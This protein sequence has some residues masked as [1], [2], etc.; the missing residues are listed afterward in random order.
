MNLPNYISVFRILLVP[1]FFMFLIDFDAA[2]THYRPI[3]LAIFLVAITTDAL[4]GIIARQLKQQTKLGTFLD[5]FAD[6]LLLLT[7]F[8]GI[9]CTEWFVIKPPNWIVILIVWSPFSLRPT[10]SL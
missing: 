7:A 10:N 4:D 9:A 6:K 3:A 5:P 1:I 8:L 2:H